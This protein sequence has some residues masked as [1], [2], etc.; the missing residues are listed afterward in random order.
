MSRPKRPDHAVTV[1]IEVAFHQ[2]DPLAVAWHGRY[3]EF[4]EAARM[5]LMASV[6]LDVPQIRDLGHRMYV[7]EVKC[8]YM[9]PLSFGETAR[10]TAWFGEVAPLIRV[11]YDI[12]HV[13]RGAWAARATTKL[14]TTDALGNLL[15][16]TPDALLQ[17]LPT[18]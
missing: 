17:R 11:S 16:S 1:D 7:T 12:L 14:A 2:C 6:G 5:K 4:F 8:R 3:F 15:P 18:L 9:V 10:V 13:E